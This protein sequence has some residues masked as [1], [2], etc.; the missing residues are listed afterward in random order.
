[1]FNRSHGADLTAPVGLIATGEAP[2]LTLLRDGVGLWSEDIAFQCRY[3]EPDV[4]LLD[5]LH[6]A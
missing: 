3:Q 4:P 2:P 6:V 1:M 5:T